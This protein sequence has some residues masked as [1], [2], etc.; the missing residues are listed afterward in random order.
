M[1]SIVNVANMCSH[2]QNATRARLA[3]TSVKNTKYNLKLSMALHRSGFVSSVYRAGAEPPTPEQMLSQE[4][5]PLTPLNVAQ[6][7]IW[8]GLKYWDGK[9]VM[10]KANVI[11]KPSRL[12]TATVPELE[13][14]TRGFS[15]K[16]SGGVI[17]GLSMGES[18]FLA[19]DKGVLE[20]REALARRVGGLLMCRVS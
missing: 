1:P 9:P 2:L 12:M 5:E 15:T 7:R 4:P 13:R 20:S 16:I 8:L 11:S 10:S 6:A 3:L 14:V 19:T 17:R 18:L